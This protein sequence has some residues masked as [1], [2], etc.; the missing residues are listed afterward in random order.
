MS[1]DWSLRDIDNYKELCWVPENPD[2]PKEEQTFQLNAVTNHLIW[3]TMTVGIQKITEANWE[4][5]YNRLIFTEKLFGKV[6][7]VPDEERED[8]FKFR[9]ITEE[10]VKAHIGLGTNASTLT[11]LQFVKNQMERFDREQPMGK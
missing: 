4:H 6:L 3:S 11:K 9:H 5:F 7:Y 2:A 10:E 1:L 8:G